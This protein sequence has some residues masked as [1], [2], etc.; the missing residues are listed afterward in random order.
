MVSQL[1]AMSAKRLHYKMGEL[2]KEDFNLVKKK[3]L[4]L[5]KNKS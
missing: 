4:A 3:F 2:Q 1:K 5:F